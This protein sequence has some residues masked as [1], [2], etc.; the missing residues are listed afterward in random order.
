MKYLLG[1]GSNIGDGRSNLK[2]A[3]EELQ[4][5]LEIVKESAVERTSPWGRNDQDDFFNSVLLAET[6]KGPRELLNLV[7]EIEKRMGRKKSERWGPRIIDI[8]I[9]WGEGIVVNK[10]G[11][12]IPHPFLHLRDFVLREINEVLPEGYH[13][14]LK[15]KFSELAD[16]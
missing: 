4:R 5:E 15:K 12:I 10:N 11:L 1:L 7:K 13:P 9:L 16:G 6:S 3:K 2:R 14:I 8:D